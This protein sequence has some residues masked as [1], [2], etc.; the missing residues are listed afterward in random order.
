MSAEIDFPADGGRLQLKFGRPRQVFQATT[1][2]QVIPAIAMAQHEA[3]AGCWV[4]GFVAYEAA[5]AFD[6]ALRVHDPEPD[7]PLAHFA[8]H[9]APVTHPDTHHGDCRSGPWRME[10]D[11]LGFDHAVAAIRADIGEGRFYQTNLTTRLRTDFSGDSSLFYRTL[12]TGQPDG[13]CIY[14]DG[15]DW[16]IL[17]VSPELF[18]DW[19]PSGRLA[20]RPMKGT[21]ARHA[22]AAADYAAAVALRG[23]E[24][25]R[26]ENLMIVDLLRND[27]S[28]VAQLGSVDVPALFDIQALPTAWQMSSSVKCLTR[29]GTGLVDIFNALFPC[30]SV[31]G[32]PKVTAMQSIV[33]NERSP[34]GAY[35][36]AIGLIRPGG[37][38]TFNVGI[39]TVTLRGTRAECGVGS[40][41]TFD[42]RAA[43][44]F[45]EW[46]VKRRF[47]L[48]ASADFKLIETLRLENGRF[49]LLE[50]HLE[51]LG[52]SAE[53]FGFDFP[54]DGVCHALAELAASHL[55][56]SWRVRLLIDRQGETSLEARRLEP[57][58][59]EVTIALAGAPIL[60]N[61]ESLRH[62]TTERS[63]YAPHAPCPNNFDT[64]LWNERN[65]ITEFTKGNV[66]VKIDGRTLTPPLS[67]GLL[68]GVMRQELLDSGDIEEGIVALGDLSRAAGVWFINSVRGRVVA[69]F[70]D[71]PQSRTETP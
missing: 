32:A 41:I 22:D 55:A 4:T 35:C 64:L 33:E 5:P 46:L 8:I 58:A 53:H 45:D 65:E 38:A 12:H 69:R 54:M 61:N 40:G 23:S 48:R 43:E 50:R 27:L 9:D 6:G 3:Q 31:T 51:R 66:V 70:A 26:A 37:H 63:A 20:T 18:F 7:L 13:Y 19:T 34:R 62:K 68:P 56:N 52:R 24:K 29:P 57:D 17:S 2:D 21:A 36:G 71:Q 11:R 49:W 14:L 44:E 42:S 25:E 47:L 16:Q 1:L 10:I 67:C 28:R 60:S 39:R 15:G 30:G 59:A